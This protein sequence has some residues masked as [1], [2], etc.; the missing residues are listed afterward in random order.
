MRFMGGDV[1][2]TGREGHIGL[3]I[4]PCPGVH[5][6]TGREVGWGSEWCKMSINLGEFL[7]MSFLKSKW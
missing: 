3:Q 2:Q 7:L 6:Y 4:V 1:V 5:L